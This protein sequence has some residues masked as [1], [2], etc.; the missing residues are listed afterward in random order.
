MELLPAIIPDDIEDLKDKLALV[1][2]LAPVVQIDILDG[3][4]VP[5]RSWPFHTNDEDYFKKLIAEEEGMPFWEDFYFEADLM[6]AEP[7]KHVEDFIFAGFSRIIVHI[8]STKH[9][10]EIIEKAR[11]L[12]T[13][14]GIAIDIETP[15][16][17]LDEWLDKIDV[18]QCM[19]I[20]EIGKQGEPFDDRVVEKIAR[21]RVANPDIIISVDGGVS[22]RTASFLL[23]AGAERLVSGSAIFEEGDPDGAIQKFHNLSQVIED[24]F[25]N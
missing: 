20:A 15:L 17:V 12:D 5:N 4:F 13:E 10:G 24:Q 11:A 21:I 16:E 7:E 8:E 19:G 23:G 1:R 25:E 18:V 9:M 2:K 22:L 3:Q 6:I 14:I